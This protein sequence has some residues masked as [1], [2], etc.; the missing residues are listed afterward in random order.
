VELS[1]SW[2]SLPGLCHSTHQLPFLT[3][4]NPVARQTMETL[5]KRKHSGLQGKDGHATQASGSALVFSGFDFA[6]PLFSQT[7]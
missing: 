4:A 6:A 5:L 7:A 1:L 2:T 3:P